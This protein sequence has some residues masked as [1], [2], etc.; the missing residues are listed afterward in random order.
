MIH[1]FQVLASILTLCLSINGSTL[2]AEIA[3]GANLLQ[4]AGFERDVQ[5][6]D[7]PLKKTTLTSAEI[8]ESEKVAH[9]G[10]RCLK[11]M[12]NGPRLGEAFP[13]ASSVESALVKVEAD[14]SYSIGLWFRCENVVK[15]DVPDVVS[16]LAIYW[17]DSG[18]NYIKHENTIIDKDGLRDGWEEILF[19]VQ[20]PPGADTAIMD[21]GFYGT[22]GAFYLDDLSF[23]SV[24]AD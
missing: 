2:I 8:F 16:V 15:S 21:I 22:D 14:K 20:S 19:S 11:V 9:S 23:S 13:F 3:E 24:L 12:P 10:Q 5:P 18:G 6:D 1:F 17:M 4:N 7:W